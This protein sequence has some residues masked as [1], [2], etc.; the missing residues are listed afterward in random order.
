MVD[1]DGT[2]IKE[3][4]LLDC[5]YA[6]EVLGGIE[7]KTASAR[8]FSEFE[9]YPHITKAVSRFAEIGI[10]VIDSSVFNAEDPEHFKF[11]DFELAYY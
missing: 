3:S 7:T 1:V 10:E 8:Q 5:C 6:I 2:S 4:F 9:K 11:I